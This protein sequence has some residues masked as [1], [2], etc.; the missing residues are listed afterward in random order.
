MF[1]CTI[2]DYSEL[3]L[4]YRHELRLAGVSLCSNSNCSKVCE[5]KDWNLPVHQLGDGKWVAAPF[6]NDCLYNLFDDHGY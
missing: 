3:E 4:Y 1:E 2:K 5:I 6:C